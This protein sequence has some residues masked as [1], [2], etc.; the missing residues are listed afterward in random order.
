VLAGVAVVTST[1]VTGG[2]YVQF[3]GLYFGSIYTDAVGE[4]LISQLLRRNLHSLHSG[5]RAARCRCGPPVSAIHGSGSWRQPL[6]FPP[7]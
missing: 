4:R 1:G 2:D 6:A 7:D 5:R 3:S